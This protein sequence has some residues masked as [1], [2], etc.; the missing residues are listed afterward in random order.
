MVKPI[1]IKYIRFFLTPAPL[2]LGAII[3]TVLHTSFISPIHPNDY[4]WYLRFAQDILNNLSVPIFDNYTYTHSGEYII[5][6]A[7]F[8]SIIF[9]WL[10][11]PTLTL[12]L[13][14]FLLLSTYL[15][16]YK[17]C[18]RSG[19]GIR[20]SAFFTFIALL[21]GSNNWVIR[22]QL[23]AYPLFALTLLYVIEWGKNYSNRIYYSPIILLFWANLH[24]SFPLFFMLVGSA[25]F[26]PNTNRKA[27]IYII[28]I[29]LLFSLVNPY[30]FD[31]WL[32]I[33]S[34][35][36]DSN[37][38]D[39]GPEWLPPTINNGWQI[40]IFFINLLF[41]PVLTSFSILKPRSYEWLLFALFGWMAIS[42]LRYVIW[43]QAIL[44]LLSAKL[45]SGIPYFQRK[46]MV[47]FGKFRINHLFFWVCVIGPMFFLPP[48]KNAWDHDSAIY[49]TN[50]PIEAIK[51]L[52]Q[53]PQYDGNIWS[54]ISM[55]P[56]IIY[57]LPERPVW[58][59]TRTNLITEEQR[60]E[61]IKISTASSDWLELIDKYDIKLL[62]LDVKGQAELIKALKK[63]EIWSLS[64]GDD[65]CKIFV[66][67]A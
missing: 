25:L 6:H 36:K 19:V 16:L 27:L 50:T 47:R 33:Y 11:S 37:I 42:G 49:T 23:F 17:C 55:S 10:K 29:S 2:W 30:F 51:W 38:R 35:L 64:Y 26:C 67:K 32:Y 34:V 12:L 61:Y 18:R 22:P 52:K 54:D 15:I 63:Y 20:M 8:S 45:M 65:Y 59:D 39:L 60:K 5:N 44:S 13:R 28:I 1:K 41:F 9:L 57:A 62:I 48:F 7:W 21:V 14:G 56:Y 53:N 43:F 58:G 31:S 66:K 4:W 40:K 24:G 3:T 46:K